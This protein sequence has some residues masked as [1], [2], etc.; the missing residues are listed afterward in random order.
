MTTL[1]LRARRRGGN[2]TDCAYTAGIHPDTVRQWRTRLQEEEEG[3]PTLDEL[4]TFFEADKKAI[5]DARLERLARIEDA[6]KK[7][8]Q[9]AAWWL[10]RKYPDEF[11]QKKRL[12]H[13]GDPDEPVV[14]KL[15]WAE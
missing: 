11:G 10:E 12:E 2:D 15:R 4:F 5:A 14:V 9:A 13:S 8:W 7:S 6:S 3:T 1:Y